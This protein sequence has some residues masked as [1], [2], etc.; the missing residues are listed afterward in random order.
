MTK[1]LVTA[2]FDAKQTY[3]PLPVFAKIT[4]ISEIVRDYGALKEHQLTVGYGPGY[5]RRIDFSCKVAA[6]DARKCYINQML[7]QLGAPSGG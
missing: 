7:S 2:A 1:L 4:Y 3:I 6:E 5:E